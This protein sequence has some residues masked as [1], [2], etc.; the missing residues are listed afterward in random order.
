MCAVGFGTVTRDGG[1][2]IICRWCG[3]PRQQRD[4]FETWNA[5]RWRNWPILAIPF[6]ERPKHGSKAGLVQRAGAGAG[7][8][9]G[10]GKAAGA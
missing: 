1:G 3:N 6:K 2:T 7:A 4:Q 9:Q 10:G 8:V 5:R